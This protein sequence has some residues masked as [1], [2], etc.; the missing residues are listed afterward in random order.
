M[1][2]CRSRFIALFA[3][4]PALAVPIPADSQGMGGMMNGGMMGGGMMGGFGQP[5]E[6]GPS[7]GSH[8]RWDE[9]SSYVQSN[10]LACMSCHTLSGRGAGPA[11]MDIA[12]RFAG[13]PDSATALATAIRNGVSGEWPGYPPMPGRLATPK[14]AGNLARLILGLAH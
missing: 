7:K 12:R 9:L 13:Q 11:Y 10:G 4:V 2:Y 6:P 14:Q 1:T 8:P 5:G 3:V